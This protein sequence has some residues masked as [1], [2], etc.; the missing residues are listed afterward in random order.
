[1]FVC[2]FPFSI[3]ENVSWHTYAYKKRRAP[4]LLIGVLCFFDTCFFI[5]SNTLHTPSCLSLSFSLFFFSFLFQQQFSFTIRGTRSS[6]YH[7]VSRQQSYHL[8]DDND[9]DDVDQEAAIVPQNLAPEQ[10]RYEFPSKARL[11]QLAYLDSNNDNAYSFFDESSFATLTTMNTSYSISGNEASSTDG[12][13]HNMYN[14]SSHEN[15][16]FSSCSWITDPV[17]DLAGDDQLDKFIE[18]ITSSYADTRMDTQSGHMPQRG[19]YW[20]HHKEPPSRFER[21]DFDD[22][23]Y[24]D[25]VMQLVDD[26]GLSPLQLP[27]RANPAVAVK[28]NNSNPRS[29]K[30]SCDSTATIIR[31][32][33]RTPLD[34]A[35]DPVGPSSFLRSCSQKRHEHVGVTGNG[36][37]HQLVRPTVTHGKRK[38]CHQGNVGYILPEIFQPRE[39]KKRKKLNKFCL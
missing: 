7:A 30:M 31:P 23:E 13:E 14:F 35:A 18:S 8:Y 38:A 25:E 28:G 17:T 15:S 11:R 22:D 5:S 12:S 32:G 33:R 26:S 16:A 24:Q 39:K 4:P 10:Y 2:L 6:L 1:M 27:A 9:N 37:D 3:F 20:N 36:V 19:T 34:A 29:R 21:H